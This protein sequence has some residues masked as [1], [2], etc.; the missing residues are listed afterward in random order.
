MRLVYM[1]TPEFSVGALE[2]LI[3]AGHD[4]CA[5]VT[6]PDR[7]KGRG[8]ELLFS[9]VKEAAL[10]HEI[11]VLQPERAKNDDFIEQLA[12]YNADI[13]VVAA[14][15]QILPKS[16]LDMPKYGCINIHASLLPRYR[17]AAPIQWC[18]INGDKST[19]VTI[20]QM[21]EGLDTGDM[22]LSESFELASDETGGSLH[23]K[24]SECGAR[25]VVRALADIEAGNINPTPQPEISTTQYASMLNKNMGKI[26]WQASA[27][28]IE[29]LIRGLSP[30]PSAFTYL[31]GKTLKI[32]KAVLVKKEA[33]LN[34]GTVFN[35]S[36]NGFCVACAVDALSIEILQLEGK[37]RM[38]T[39]DFLRGCVLH[40]GDL[41][42]ENVE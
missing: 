24:L 14:Y 19:G 5:V 38:D 28:E 1:G 41:L 6:Q 21:D 35:V 36:K 18:I 7:K 42:G 3:D 22:L 33:D 26:N 39:A 32:W 11:E 2:A 37:K 20:M 17:G 25:L 27:E 31:N 8:Q 23:D 16:I 34:P 12:T 15:G 13:F 40:D 9:P 30:W 4:V 10:K 29:R